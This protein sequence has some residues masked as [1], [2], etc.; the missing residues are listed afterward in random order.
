ME[1]QARYLG[2]LWSGDNE[3]AKALQDDETMDEMLKLRHE[4]LLC[5]QF[6]MGDYAYLM[7]S[8]SRILGIQRY[9]PNNPTERTGRFHFLMLR[10]TMRTDDFRYCAPS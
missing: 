7:E 1:M 5:A 10:E 2:K 6:P 9:E 8:F 4:P 3:A